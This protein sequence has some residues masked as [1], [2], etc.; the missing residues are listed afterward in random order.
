MMVGSIKVTFEDE[1]Y[2][3]RSLLYRL[4]IDSLANGLESKRVIS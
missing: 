1:R 3:N 4:H 2:N